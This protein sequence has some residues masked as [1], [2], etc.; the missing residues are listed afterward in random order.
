MFIQVLGLEGSCIAPCILL[1]TGKEGCIQ[2]LYLFNVPEG[3]VITLNV[4]RNIRH[5]INASYFYLGLAR[6]ALE[7]RLL[8]P[9]RGRIVAI[10]T[11]GIDAAHVGGLGALTLRASADGI[12][13]FSR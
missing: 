8:R 12:I 2:P 7:H 9:S 10:F 13:K 5:F 11:T 3:T 6:F 4:K 1:H